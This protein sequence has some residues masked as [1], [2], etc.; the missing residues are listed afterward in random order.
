[1]RASDGLLYVKFDVTGYLLSEVVVR[2][3]PSQNGYSLDMSD[4]S[5][6]GAVLKWPT[7]RPCRTDRVLQ[8]DLVV[9]EY[10][11]VQGRGPRKEARLGARLELLFDLIRPLLPRHGGSWTQPLLWGDIGLMEEDLDVPES[12]DVAGLQVV[13]MDSVW[14]NEAPIQRLEVEEDWLI[15]FPAYA[16]MFPGE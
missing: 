1:M 3:G 15:T 16:G 10:L 9:L 14:P 7:V 5:Y 11:L 6:R 2:F 8:Y 13:A 4:T 12:H